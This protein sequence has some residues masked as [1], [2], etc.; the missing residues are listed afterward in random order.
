[1][2]VPKAVL[3]DPRLIKHTLLDREFLFWFCLQGQLAA[4]AQ[5]YDAESLDLEDDADDIDRTLRFLW[6][7]HLPFSP[8][9]TYDEFRSYITWSPMSELMAISTKVKVSQLPEGTKK[10]GKPK[11]RSKAS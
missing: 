7:G 10:Q 1:M 4:K 11:R 6:I 9:M 8:D 5:G 2:I 3:S